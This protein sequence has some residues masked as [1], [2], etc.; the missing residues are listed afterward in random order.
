MTKKISELTAG[1]AVA[2]AH[3]FESS[4]ASLSTKVTATQLKTYFL[5]GFTAAGLAM[6]GAASAAAQTALLSN[7]IGDSGAGGTKGLVPAPAA[8]DAAA[9]RFLKSDGTWAVPAG[10]GATQAF[11]T[12]VVSGQSDIVA[13][14]APDTLTIVAGAN[15]TLTTNAGTDTLTI[16]AAGGSGSPG[17]SDTQVQFNDGGA[18]GGDS[19]FT[20][21]KTTNLATLTGTDGASSLLIASGSQTGSSSPALSITQ[22]WNNAATTFTGI[23]V[24]ITNTASA[25]ALMLLDLQVGGSS[26]FYVR[27]NGDIYNGAGSI[28]TSGGFF[29]RRA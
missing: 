19:G 29:S 17:G 28:Y 9:G 24:N 11:G 22:T 14:A 15:V 16:A 13:D 26:K 27:K 25:T 20:F 2:D 6:G 5:A 12:I 4:Q 8:G 3:L 23:L 21:N 7:F 1:A 18:F 10:G